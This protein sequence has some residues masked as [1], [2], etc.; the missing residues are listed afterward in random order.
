VKNFKDFLLIGLIIVAIT[1]FMYLI[2]PKYQVHTVKLDEDY[3]AITKINT[4]TGEVSTNFKKN[5]WKRFE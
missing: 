5:I 4:I 1:G 2:M 3:V